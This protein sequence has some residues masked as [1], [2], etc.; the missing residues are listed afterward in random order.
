MIE[1]SDVYLEKFSCCLNE[2]VVV[3]KVESGACVMSVCGRH[4]EEEICGNEIAAERWKCGDVEAT[5]ESQE[6]SHEWILMLG[7]GAEAPVLIDGRRWEAVT[8]LD[9]SWNAKRAWIC[10]DVAT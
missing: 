10:V 9:G 4:C 7:N 1:E 2:C 5:A 3:G 8:L 6:E